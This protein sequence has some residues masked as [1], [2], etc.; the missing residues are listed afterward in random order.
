[1]PPAR[2]LH[3]GIATVMQPDEKL[4]TAL[5]RAAVR[6]MSKFHAHCPD[7]TARAGATMKQ[8]HA[9]LSI[10]LVRAPEQ[11]MCEFN[12]QRLSNARHGLQQQ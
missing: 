1:M 4:F 5:T 12:V 8:P 9:N 3:L 11:A 7:N 2:F 6:R 10:V